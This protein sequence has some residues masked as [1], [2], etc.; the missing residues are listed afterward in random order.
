MVAPDF[1]QTHSRATK[2]E[3]SK[4]S[5][6]FEY[7]D[8]DDLTDNPHY[9]AQQSQENLFSPPNVLNNGIKSSPDFKNNV[10]SR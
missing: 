5:T 7:F 9:T 8:K 10:D 3:V 6:S 2:N 1:V 4:V